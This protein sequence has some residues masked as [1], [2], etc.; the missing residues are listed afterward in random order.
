MQGCDAHAVLTPGLTNVP[1]AE[2]APMSKEL[3][4]LQIADVSAFARTLGHALHERHAAKPA[5]P[6]QVELLNLIARAQG[7]RNWQ[8][9]RQALRLA[10]PAAA[11]PSAHP[12]AAAAVPLSDNAR[13]ALAHFDTHGRLMRWPVKFSI[14]KLVMWVLW[15]RFDAKRS[16]TESEVNTI[17][18]AANMFFDHATLRRELINHRLMARKSDCSDYRKLP[19]RPDDEARALLTAWRARCREA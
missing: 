10:P 1:G 17:L 2:E 7:Q 18:K 8:A 3:F 6:G 11:R 12:A 14:Q 19:A 9:L 13:K 15:T 4:A 16:Y 5:P